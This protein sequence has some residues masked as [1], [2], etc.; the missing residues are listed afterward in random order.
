MT[1]SSTF[2]MD[3]LSINKK[4]APNDSISSEEIDTLVN[5]FTSQLITPAT[6]SGFAKTVTTSK[7][8]YSK[9]NNHQK[10]IKLAWFDNDCKVMTKTVTFALSAWRRSHFDQNLQKAYHDT[11]SAWIRL[12]KAK[13]LK[14]INGTLKFSSKSNPTQNHFGNS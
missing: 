10:H 1:I 5:S 7:R 6:A 9:P 13:K 8:P 12:I 3:K 11:K 4:L 14:R 2:F